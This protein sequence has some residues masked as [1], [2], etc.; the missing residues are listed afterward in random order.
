MGAYGRTSEA[1][2]PPY[3]WTLSG[4][5]T[6]DGRVYLDD[7]SCQTADWLIPDPKSPG[8]LNRDALINLADYA[9][10]SGDWLSQTSWFGT[11][12]DPPPYAHAWNPNPPDE[13]EVIGYYPVLSWKPGYGA[14][15]HDVYFGDEYP[16][17]F[18]RNQTATTFEPGPLS[19]NTTY[20]WRI[21]EVT[22][23]QT[24]TGPVW[25]FTTSGTTR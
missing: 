12:S 23:Y 10:L 24:T 22:P 18:K 7:L 5:I 14:I 17:E 16:P 9:T 13:A 21:D 6:N 15:S 1:S 11:P 19:S 3:G 2:I 25:T 4:D 20:Y 8:N